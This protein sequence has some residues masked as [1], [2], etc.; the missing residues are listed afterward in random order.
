MKPKDAA[1]IFD[2]LELPVL[3]DVTGRMKEAKLAPVLA[4][5][6][7]ERARILTVKLAQRRR[8]MEGA[9]ADAKAALGTDPTPAT[10][11]AGAAPADDAKK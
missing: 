10:P 9:V 3:V 2:N 8:D 6:T 5:M 4:A 1:E 11:A 7:P